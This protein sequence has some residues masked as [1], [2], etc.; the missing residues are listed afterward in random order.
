MKNEE[1]TG[2]DINAIN[3]KS[4]NILKNI[5]FNKNKNLLQSK[6]IIN[7]EIEINNNYYNNMNKKGNKSSNNSITFNKYITKRAYNNEINKSL[8]NTSNDA[9]EDSNEQKNKNN[10]RS[11]TIFNYNDRRINKSKS[12][13]IENN[14][15]NMYK[16]TKEQNNLNNKQN[17]LSTLK[18]K[19]ANAYKKNINIFNQKNRAN[20][21]FKIKN[22][23]I[24]FK[25]KIYKSLGNNGQK[26]LTN[27]LSDKD[28]S[29]SLSIDDLINKVN[30]QGDKNNFPRYMEELKLK[31]DITSIV[32]NM[33]KNEINSYDGLERFLE[34]YSKTKEKYEKTL[35][36]YKYLLKRLIQMNQNVGD[37]EIN[38][39]C[40]EIYS[41]QNYNYK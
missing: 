30:Y 36:M 13:F 10:E 1:N 3:Y 2:N 19:T 6:K 11:N 17:L 31:A 29:D 26:F 39:F 27:N 21:P 8:D 23:K 33:F 16:N 41:Y 24:S 15:I 12:Y 40:D 25:N 37:K 34:N 18:N 14:N 35:N 20:N 4:N 9:I 5:L 22:K 28:S 7:S 32:Q 38:S